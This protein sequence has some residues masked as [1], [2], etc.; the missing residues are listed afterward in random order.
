VQLPPELLSFISPF[1]RRLFAYSGLELLQLGTGTSQTVATTLQ[2]LTGGGGHVMLSCEGP[3]LVE[4]EGLMQL[5][6]QK[7]VRYKLTVR[8]LKN[9]GAS[10]IIASSRAALRLRS[11]GTELKV[12][13]C[14]IHFYFVFFG[15]NLNL[16]VCCKDTKN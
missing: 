16:A 10:S 14:K 13:F 11:T 3:N 1:Y 2:G 15:E 5:L 7:Q 4:R 8:I 6:R 9:R 12:L